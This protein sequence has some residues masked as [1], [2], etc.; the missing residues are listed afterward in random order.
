MEPTITVATTSGTSQKTAPNDHTIV[1]G[2]YSLGSGSVCEK[3]DNVWKTLDAPE[4][5]QAYRRSIESDLAKAGIAVEQ[6]RDW[7]VMDVGTGRQAIVFH[8]LGAKS[9]HH[10]DQSP[11]NVQNLNR[12]ITDRAL[13]KQLQSQCADLV[14]DPLPQNF[15]DFMY[16]N[17]VVQHFSHTGAGLRNCVQALKRGGYLWVYF[18]RSGT[19]LMFVLSMIRDVIQGYAADV[20]EHFVNSTLLYS[21]IVQPNLHISNIMDDLF[22]PYIHLYSPTSYIAFLQ[23]YGLDIVSSSKL[24]PMGKEVDHD[25]A[26]H[27]VVLTCRKVREIDVSRVDAGTLSPQRSINQLT[28]EQYATA[29]ILATL[30]CYQGLKEVLVAKQVPSSVRMCLAFRLYQFAQSMDNSL[31]S[32]R[33]SDHRSL[34]TILTNTTRLMKDEL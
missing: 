26:H 29:D 8:Q 17:G 31:T 2:R 25:F 21:D 19:F 22:V 34:Q 33:Y 11:H 10:Y 27:S 14:T 6:L 7:T 23:T 18:Y 5:I 4:V 28:P 12:F 1:Y 9:V 32:S 13:A 3:G 24:D 15:F 20:R 30:S 16:L